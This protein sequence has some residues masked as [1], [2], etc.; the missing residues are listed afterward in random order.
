GISVGTEDLQLFLLW[1]GRVLV[2]FLNRLSNIYDFVV[3][4]LVLPN[5]ITVLLTDIDPYELKYPL[6]DVLLRSKCHSQSYGGDSDFALSVK[7]VS[8]GIE[9]LQ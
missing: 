6:P 5:R 3:G 1:V 2:F 7:G 9:D 8:V 4:F